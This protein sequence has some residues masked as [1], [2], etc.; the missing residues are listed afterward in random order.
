MS[1][2]DD[3]CGWSSDRRCL[4]PKGHSG[5]HVCSGDTVNGS[6]VCPDC[7]GSGVIPCFNC[8]ETDEHTCWIDG[9]EYGPTECYG[10]AHQSTQENT[11]SPVQ[12]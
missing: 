10:T 4:M 6:T 3:L 2:G 7:D 9:E 5:A 12:P 11:D 8:E 1:C